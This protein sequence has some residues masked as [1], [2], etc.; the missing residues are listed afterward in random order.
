MKFTAAYTYIAFA[1][2]QASAP[3]GQARYPVLGKDSSRGAL[4]LPAKQQPPDD[5]DTAAR[6]FLERE[7]AAASARGAAT[8]L[9]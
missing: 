1:V 5:A 2:A 4:K 9:R 3:I 8:A 7:D 6:I